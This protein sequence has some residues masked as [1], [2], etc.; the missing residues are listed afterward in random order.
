MM[1]EP[2]VDFKGLGASEPGDIAFGQY[3]IY[4]PSAHKLL[5]VFLALNPSKSILW[6]LYHITNALIM[7]FMNEHF[8][9]QYSVKIRHN[10]DRTPA[11]D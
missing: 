11:N 1:Q 9:N 8:F 6:F 10:F 4:V 5:P 7:S 2:K 3:E